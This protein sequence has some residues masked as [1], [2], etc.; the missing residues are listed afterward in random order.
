M[1][2]YSY[3]E[4]V[5]RQIGKAF[6]AYLNCCKGAEGVGPSETATRW[7]E[8]AE[9]WQE[10]IESLVKDCLP[11][12]SGFDAGTQFDWD[13]S[14]ADRLVFNTSYHHMNDGGYYDGWTE[15]TITVTP[16]FVGMCDLKVSGRDRRSI[17]EYIAETF[18]N[19]LTL[20][21]QDYTKAR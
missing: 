2:Q 18:H 14:K 21:P 15:H 20:C 16:S 1:P 10:T 11:S 13:K 7:K 19:A 5:V 3:S 9:R 17:K 12:G 4:P 6:D 8:N